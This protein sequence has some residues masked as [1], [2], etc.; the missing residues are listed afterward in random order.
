MGD[1]LHPGGCMTGVK[2]AAFSAALADCDAAT[3]DYCPE[4]TP[5]HV[6]DLSHCG[7]RGRSFI[8]TSPLPKETR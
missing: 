8:G 2:R 3:V 5:A 7:R 1:E 4:G 6:D